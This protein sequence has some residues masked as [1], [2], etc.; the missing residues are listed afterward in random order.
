MKKTELIIKSN[1][2]KKCADSA[3]QYS[4]IKPENGIEIRYSLISDLINY[5]F[6]ENQYRLTTFKTQRGIVFKEKDFI[7]ELF[8][9]KELETINNFKALKKQIEWM[10]GRCLI[11]HMVMEY[12]LPSASPPHS[13]KI[14]P[15]D[16]I[17]SHHDE[18]APF[19]EK[20]PFWEISISH[21]DKYAA[22]ALCTE[23]G[24][25]IGLDIEKIGKMPDSSFMKLAFTEKEIANL[26]HYPPHS[27][28]S[29]QCP[30]KI[31][32]KWTIKEAFLKYIKKGFNESLHKVEILDN[33]IFHNNKK[34]DVSIFS[35]IIK[36][37]TK[38]RYYLSMVS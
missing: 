34:A 16:I 9:R 27:E 22:V 4:I 6:P 38:D 8:S 17:I 35:T 33:Q 24:K 26:Q 28:N 25:K 37:S 13:T 10:A 32:K 3:L 23:K 1:T 11:K 15:C 29:L 5:A 7:P 18:G 2:D 20:R 14:K 19:L 30:K 12:L 36:D 21:S 31:F